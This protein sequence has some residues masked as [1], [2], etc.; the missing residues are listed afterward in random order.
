MKLL[1]LEINSHPVNQDNSTRGRVNTSINMP[2]ANLGH[3]GLY[4]VGPRVSY[5]WVQPW[6]EPPGYR[7]FSGRFTSRRC[8]RSALEA[9]SGYRADRCRF[10][11]VDSVD[12]AHLHRHQGCLQGPRGF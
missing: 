1:I 8:L 3:V 12:A 7:N 10:A 5:N 11:P 4:Y 2:S 9:G 6:R